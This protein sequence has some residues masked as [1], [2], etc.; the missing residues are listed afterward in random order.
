MIRYALAA[1]AA[2]SSL[3]VAGQAA[4]ATRM[5]ESGVLGGSA[6]RLDYMIG[7]TT[8]F[9]GPLSTPEAFSGAGTYSFALNIDPAKV[10]SLTPYFQV[11]EWG[12]D[13][14]SGA[15]TWIERLVTPAIT[16]T[17]TDTGYVS[18]AFTLPP[19]WSDGPSGY[20]VY[21]TVGFDVALTDYTQP[22]Y[23]ITLNPQP[24]VTRF[25]ALRQAAAAVPEPSTWAML[26]LG[27]LGLGA[28]LRV[29][30]YGVEVV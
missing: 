14:S 22:A 6:H 17:Q 30:R 7:V 26:L 20:T 15:A 27:V 2:A 8:P 9:A 19:D 29:R 23:S 18:S 28:A 5:L 12:I 13:Y 21:G 10:A 11:E 4:A 16:I 3:A 25:A 24:P 1:F